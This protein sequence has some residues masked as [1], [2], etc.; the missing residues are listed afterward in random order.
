[1]KFILYIYSGEIFIAEVLVSRFDISKWVVYKNLRY[2]E[3][4]EYISIVSTVGK[5]GGKQYNYQITDKLK[6]QLKRSIE[7][8]QD[9]LTYFKK[10]ENKKK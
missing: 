4:Q 2:W 8:L 1:V 5:K 7:S 6:T 3:K 10:K 9:S